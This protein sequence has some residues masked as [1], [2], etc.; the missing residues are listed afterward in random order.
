MSAPALRIENETRGSLL[1]ERIRLADRWWSRLRGLLGR[2]EPE[3]G[4]GLMLVPCRGVHMFGM[5][6]PLDVLLMDEEGEVLE[7]YESLE[8]W[9]RTG[10]HGEA[11]YALELPAGTVG[12]TGTEPGDRLSW[13][14]APS[15]GG[16]G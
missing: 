7:V 2:P 11:R 13:T 4:E 16:A 1:G 6:Y 10:F 9:G 15:D 5:S 3:E 14:N 8:P 12:G